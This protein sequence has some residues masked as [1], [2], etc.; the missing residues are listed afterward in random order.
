[1]HK[2]SRLAAVAAALLLLAPAAT[3]AQDGAIN[4]PEA[5]RSDVE[6]IHQLFANVAGNVAIDN[7]WFTPAWPHPSFAGWPEPTTVVY[8]IDKGGGAYYEVTLSEIHVADFGPI[9]WQQEREIMPVRD[10]GRKLGVKVAAGDTFVD[11]Y[12]HTF[13][14]VQ[15]LEEETKL[16]FTAEVGARLGALAT[17]AGANL[18]LKVSREYADRFSTSATATD[19]VTQTLTVQ[20]PADRTYFAFRDRSVVERTTRCRPVLDYKIRIGS[21]NPNGSGYFADWSSKAELLRFLRGQASDDVG[22]RH[23]NVNPSLSGAMAHFFRERPQ[24]GAAIDGG[25]PVLEWTDRYSNFH[26]TGLTY[27]E[28]DE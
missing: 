11:T 4:L 2:F 18:S 1:M 16:N 5:L 13:S 27:E 21:W 26:R 17:P 10:I 25:Y 15:T 23:H 7:V 28:E 22:Y 3:G 6:R 19:T 8:R 9:D 12:T 14:H 24:P 20:G